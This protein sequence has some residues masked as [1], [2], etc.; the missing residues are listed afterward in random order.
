MAQFKYTLPSGAEFELQAPTGTTQAQ[1]D[2]A[3]YS[4]VAAGALVGFVPGQSV[5]GSTSTLAKFT[6]SRLNR[7]TAGVGVGAGEG[8][9]TG[10]RLGERAAGT[11][12]GREERDV[13]PVG[14]EFVGLARG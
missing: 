11:G 1:A 7:G 14:V 6:L 4:Q 5:S 8:E 10:A 13:L 2:Y 9:G 3:F 12:Q